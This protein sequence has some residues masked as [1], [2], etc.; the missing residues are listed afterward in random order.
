MKEIIEQIESERKKLGLSQRT[1]AREVG[2]DQAHI[3][4]ILA[5]TTQ[6]LPDTLIRLAEAVGGS[7]IFVPN[8]E[9]K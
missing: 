7:I 3:C 1:I 5:G 6:P 9:E 8:C 2:T 4:R